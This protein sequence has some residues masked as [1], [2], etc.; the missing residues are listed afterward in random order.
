MRVAVLHRY[1][2][3][4]TYAA[5]ICEALSAAGH[6]VRYLGHEAVGHSTFQHIR[7]IRPPWRGPIPPLRS[8]IL[9]VRDRRSWHLD[10][11]DVVIDLHAE[12]TLWI[13]HRARAVRVVHRTDVFSG[14]GVGTRARRARLRWVSRR[15]DRFIVHT[16]VARSAIVDI[17]GEHSV[18]RVP[19]PGPEPIP[20]APRARDG[21]APLL[22]VGDDRPEKGLDLVQAAADATGY[23]VR[24]VG[25]LEY[26]L[27][28][29][30]LTAAYVEC[31]A[32][33]CPY[34]DE[35]TATGS[36]SLVV[37]EAIAHAV[38][39][40][41]TPNLRDLV[42]PGYGGVEFSRAATV[43]ALTETLRGL[44]VARLSACAAAE[45][46]AAARL[47][48]PSAYVSAIMDFVRSSGA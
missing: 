7:T 46:P 36:S 26:P 28:D 13:L 29:D 20:R 34:R 8:W 35:Y 17:A 4:E 31:L 19:L 25:G 15:G 41:A 40:V 10:D 42:P 24:C 45:G 5:R 14:R 33:V 47:Q 38:P 12:A 18:A 27:S 2:R 11:A 30:E 16:D 48:S 37:A 1:R 9:D 32:V 39:L 6:D 23:V 43:A 3:H 22:F 21:A 44:D